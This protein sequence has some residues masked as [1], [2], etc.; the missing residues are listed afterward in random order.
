V[1]TAAKE[2]KLWQGDSPLEGVRLGRRTMVRKKRLPKAHHLIEW[3]AAIPETCILPADHARAAALTAI[4]SGMRVSEVLGLEPD[5]IDLFERTVDIDRGWCRGDHGPTKTKQSERKRY[6][7]PLAAQLLEIGRGKKFIFGRT[8]KDRYGRPGDGNPPDDRD[9][10]QHVWRPAAEAVGIYHPGF[11]MHVFRRLYVTW[12]QEAGATPLEAMKGA[13]HSKVDT[14][15][16]YT[17]TDEER[18]RQQVDW[19]LERI[20]GGGPPDKGGKIQ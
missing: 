19:I 3:L 1:F 9:L 17:I 14:T 5:D 11:G 8:G 13:G 20:M 16:L 7:G 4:A 12:R 18:E 2:W 10:Q 6:I 15:L